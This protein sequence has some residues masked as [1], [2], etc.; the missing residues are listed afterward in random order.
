MLHPP[1][2]HSDHLAI[3]VQI[4]IWVPTPP[5]T[6]LRYPLMYTSKHHLVPVYFCMYYRCIESR[7]PSLSASLDTLIVVMIKFFR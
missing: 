1:F 7:K 3:K 4:T 6:K 5:L 2:F